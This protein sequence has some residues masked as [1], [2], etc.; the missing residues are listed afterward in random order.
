MIDPEVID[1]LLDVIQIEV[2]QKRLPAFSIGVVDGGRR[3]SFSIGLGHA[4]VARTQPASGDTVYRVGSVSKLFTD[5]AVM[6]L[7]ERGEIIA[8]RRPA[9]ANSRIA[10]SDRPRRHRSRCD[11]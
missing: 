3:A 7:V 6:Q 11:S 9:T 4:D 8:G 2:Q 10:S 1:H 5:L